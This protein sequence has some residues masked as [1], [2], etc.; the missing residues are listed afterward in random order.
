MGEEWTE[1]PTVFCNSRSKSKIEQKGTLKSP[2][3][4]VDFVP[5]SPKTRSDR[6]N[7]CTI[8]FGTEQ[9]TNIRKVS[10]A[11]LED[12]KGLFRLKTSK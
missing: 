11:L 6:P 9:G 7:N 5:Q 2:P 1:T 12:P 8:F 10:D 3:S 4:H